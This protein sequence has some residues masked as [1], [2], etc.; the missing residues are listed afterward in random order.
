MNFSNAMKLYFLCKGVFH[1]SL[2]G[3]SDDFFDTVTL[4][5]NVG[6]FTCGETLVNG[7]HMQFIC[8]NRYIHLHLRGKNLLQNKRDRT[9]LSTQVAVDFTNRMRSNL[10]A[11]CRWIYPRYD[12]SIA[13]NC[14]YFCLQLRVFLPAIVGIFAFDCRGFCLQKQVILHDSRGQICWVPLVRLPVKYPL[15]SGIFTCGCR[16]FACI[17]REVLAA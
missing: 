2:I 7:P 6:T 15:C 8:K 11:I 17:L 3:K 16:Q 13:W 14:G 10:P 4:L 12:S 9:Y 1:C 5:T